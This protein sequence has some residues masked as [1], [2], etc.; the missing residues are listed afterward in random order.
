[1]ITRIQDTLRRMQCERARITA[2]AV[3]LRADVSRSFLYQN[4]EARRLL[5]EATA[6]IPG[7]HARD[8]AHQDAAGEAAW[9]ERALNAEEGLKSAHQ[10]VRI[11][12]AR[13][14]EL[15]GRIRDLELDL[16]A[17]ALQRLAS[18]NTTLRDRLRQRESEIKTLTER[19]SAARANNRSQDGEIANLQAQLLDSPDIVRHLRPI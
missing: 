12:R 4:P 16:P 13:T 6:H 3:A 8:L 2:Q 10:E 1:M 14:G 19:L 15:L 11:L 5:H 18:D 7:Q 17:D 9:R